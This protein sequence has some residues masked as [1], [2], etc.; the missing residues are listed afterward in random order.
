MSVH[1]ASLT[2]TGE[3]TKIFMILKYFL[4]GFN[5]GFI[6]KKRDGGR[7]VDDNIFS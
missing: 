4:A 6:M 3:I 5:L 2:N 7:E 1:I